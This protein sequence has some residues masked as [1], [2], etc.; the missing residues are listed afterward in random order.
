M[1][2]RTYSGSTANWRKVDDRE[3]RG[4]ELLVQ[5]L[6]RLNVARGDQRQRGFVNPR[7]VADDQQGVNLGRGLAQQ[8]ED[9]LRLRRVE[10][11]VEIDRRGLG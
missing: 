4:R 1:I 10:P 7:V 6:A 3:A 11:L 8:S 9:R 5:A 2:A